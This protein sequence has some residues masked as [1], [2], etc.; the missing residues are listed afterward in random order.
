[1]INIDNYIYAQFQGTPLSEIIYGID[2]LDKRDY[3]GVHKYIGES[4]L[5]IRNADTY[6]LNCWGSYLGH[7]RVYT[8]PV[9]PTTSGW[10]GF[11][12]PRLNFIGNFNDGAESF[13]ITLDDNL[14]RKKLLMEAFLLTTSFDLFSINR[15]LLIAFGGGIVVDTTVYNPLSPIK[16]VEPM[17]IVYYMHLKRIDTVH[18]LALHNLYLPKPACVNITVVFWDNKQYNGV[19]EY[20]GTIEHTG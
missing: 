7:P 12:K 11:T 8:L 19:Y 14:Y 15:A 13:T 9:P 1:M 3:E 2:K 16:A 6:G 4:L 20:D 5:D 18:L 17:K 10:F